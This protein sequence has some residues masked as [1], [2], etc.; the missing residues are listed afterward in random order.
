MEKVV[1]ANENKPAAFL[2]LSMGGPYLAT[3][4]AT[5]VDA[6]WKAAHVDFFYSISGV[7]S[8]AGVAPMV[9][10]SGINTPRV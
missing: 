9:A 3:F 10:F 5:H 8:G 7:M 4:F 6:A 1:A 2:S